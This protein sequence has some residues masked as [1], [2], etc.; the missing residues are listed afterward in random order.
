V[1]EL[2]SIVKKFV[3]TPFRA[4]TEVMYRKSIREVAEVV[5]TT[6]ACHPGQ[7]SRR[8]RTF[9]PRHTYEVIA[10]SYLKLAT[11]V[12]VAS[13]LFL[14]T[15][16]GQGVLRIGMTASDIPR[17]NGI[18]DNGFEGYR[19]LGYPIFEGLVLWDL[20]RTDR[21]ADLRPGLAEG[22]EQAPDD[23]KTWV[24][25]LRHGVK[26][27]DG[28]NFDADVVIWNFER[29]FKNDSPQFDVAGSG[30]MRARLPTLVGYRKIDDYTVALSTIEPTSYFPYLV[31]YMLFVS[32]ASFEKAGTTGAVWQ[33]C[34]L[35][36][37][38][39]SA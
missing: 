24:F 25:H 7:G 28:T 6:G 3:S 32:P 14:P 2:G 16:H 34:L 9:D 5:E 13:A 19:F 15:A 8:F 21:V 35:P 33:P 11:A 4:P 37:R 38:G 27:H 12:F 23:K 31:V 30:L 1:D 20:S 17:S 29:F 26:F 18:P 36:E 22:Y 10:M 39:R